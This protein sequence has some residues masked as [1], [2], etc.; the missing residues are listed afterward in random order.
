VRYTLDEAWEGGFWYNGNQLAQ[1]GQPFCAEDIV[2]IIG[3]HPKSPNAIGAAMNSLA[4]ELKLTKV[5]YR[6]AKR[7]SR[8]AAVIAV[9]QLI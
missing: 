3:P 8:H 2:A 7:P 1:T 9:W 6:K 5:G 4:C